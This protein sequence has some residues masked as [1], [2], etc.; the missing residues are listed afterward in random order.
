MTD[1]IILTSAQAERNAELGEAVMK[2]MLTFD[3]VGKSWMEK[4]C[5]SILQEVDFRSLAIALKT[6]PVALKTKML[7][8]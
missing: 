7:H 3:E 6:A 1:S 4:P 8:P 2:K 5:K